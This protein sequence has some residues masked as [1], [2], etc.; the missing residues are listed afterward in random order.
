MEK[1]SFFSVR[2]DLVQVDQS[3]PFDLYVNSSVI[4]GKEKF[5][6]IFPRGGV[7]AKEDLEEFHRKYIQLYVPEDQR[8]I[9]LRSLVKSGQVNDIQ[10]SNVIKDAAL[11]Y[12]HNIFDKNK[13]FSTE[14]LSQSIEG[15]REVVEN[16]VDVLDNHSIDSLRNLIGNLSFHDFY[17]YD[18]SINV[19]MYCITIMRAIKPN[20]T[21]IELVHA[22]LGG[23]LHDLGKIKIPTHILNNPGGLSQD[24][25]QTIKQHPDF[26]IEL[27]LSRHVEVAQDLDLKIISRVI[28]EHH[29]NFDGTGYPR[30]L[31]GKEE[32]HLLAR[33][34]TIADFFDAIT[35]KRSYNEVLLIPD[36]MSTMRKFR[37]IKLD[38]DIFDIFDRHVRYVRAEQTR[39]LKLSDNFDPTLPYAQLPLEEIRRLEKELDFGK[40]KILDSNEK[41]KKKEGKKR[42]VNR[43][44]KLL[45]SRLRFS[46]VF[47][48]RNCFPPFLVEGLNI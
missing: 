4:S 21:R 19:S 5:V 12:L 47:C 32:I 1:L 34:C 15:C 7:L 20:A 8:K 16:M 35:T 43:P 24:D 18:H 10:K 39:D 13:E 26:G 36:A 23:L 38:P 11:D 41:K 6:R 27:L 46:F 45:L 29:E 2:Y 3:L 31:K 17:T 33:V 9:Y 48:R 28:H 40:I 44:F 22:G 30:K 42:P 25:Y 14:L 37:G